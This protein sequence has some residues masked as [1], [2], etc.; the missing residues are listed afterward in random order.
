MRRLRYCP[1]NIKLL[2]RCE[3]H[4]IRRSFGS[5][6]YTFEMH[7]FDAVVAVVVNGKDRN[8]CISL[9]L[10]DGSISFVHIYWPSDS[11]TFLALKGVRALQRF[12]SCIYTC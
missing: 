12:Q 4:G 8:L 10:G 11:T 1:V 6:F 2:L 7:V 3:R 5:N 9:D